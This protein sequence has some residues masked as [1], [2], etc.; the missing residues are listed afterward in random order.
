MICC[1]LGPHG[2]IEIN[3]LITFESGHCVSKL[4]IEFHFETLFIWFFQFLNG[5]G[6][7]PLKY[8]FLIP[9]DLIINRNKIVFFPLQLAQYHHSILVTNVLVMVPPSSSAACR[10]T[11]SLR[12][13]YSITL[14]CLK[15]LYFFRRLIAITWTARPRWTGFT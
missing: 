11:P 9:T 1:S 12:K 2:W 8:C 5:S 15:L 6:D 3:S 7:Q 14:Y 10:A 4:L 13:S